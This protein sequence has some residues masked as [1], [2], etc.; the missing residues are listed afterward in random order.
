MWEN[1]S[2]VRSILEC[3][4]IISSPLHQTSISRIKIMQNKFLRLCGFKLGYRRTDKY[5]DLMVL[6]NLSI[7]EQSWA[8]IAMKLLHKVVNPNINCWSVTEL[9]DLNV[10]SKISRVSELFKV[11]HHGTRYGLN[12]SFTWVFKL[13]NQNS[14]L[15]IIQTFLKKSDEK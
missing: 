13:V 7:L 15:S 2:L 11:P 6:L 4:C 1:S 5:F 10:N 3:N 9:M 8:E 12:K 14:V